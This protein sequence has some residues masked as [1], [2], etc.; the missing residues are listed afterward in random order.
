MSY[1]RRSSAGLVLA[2]LLAGAP[3]LTGAAPTSPGSSTF[4]KRLLPVALED[5]PLRASPT[6]FA[7]PAPT[8]SAVDEVFDST[9]DPDEFKF[10]SSSE[11]TN[12]KRQPSFKF[13]E[14]AQKRRVHSDPLL[15]AR[16]QDNLAIAATK[17]NSKLSTAQKC[18]A[19]GSDQDDINALLWAGGAKTKVQLCPSTTYYLNDTIYF[20]AAA[21]ELSTLGYPT[22]NTRATLVVTGQNQ[23]CAIYAAYDTCSNLMIRSIQINGNRPTM[24]RM[25]VCLSLS[26]TW[27]QLTRNLPFRA[28]LV[29]LKLVVMVEPKQSEIVISMSLGVGPPYILLVGSISV[30]PA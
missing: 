23:S 1:R 16:F 20:S 4:D 15:K 25:A 3:L 30:C 5:E 8:F 11:H 14:E 24:G 19:A 29:W 27:K 26:F 22:D 9:L 2:C 28:V 6:N 12:W 17:A 13:H 18:L 10:L 7:P 21:Q